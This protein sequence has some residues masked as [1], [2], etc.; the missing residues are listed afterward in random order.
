MIING[1]FD[2]GNCGGNCNDISEHP[3]KEIYENSTAF[4]SVVHPGAGHG[5]NFN[6]NATGAYGV[7]VDFVTKNG[8]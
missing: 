5:I 6:F 3:A 4:E 2:L 1:E 8:L 7:M